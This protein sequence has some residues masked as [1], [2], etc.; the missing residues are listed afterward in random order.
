MSYYDDTLKK[1]DKLIDEEKYEE[2]LDI[3]KEELSLAYV[4]KEFEDKFK[5]LL[6]QISQY[7]NNSSKELSDEEIINYLHSDKE[8]QLIGVSVLASKNLRNYVDEV[9]EYLSGDG[10]INAKVILIDELI[11]QELSET[12]KYINEGVEYEFIP[13]YILSPENSDGYLE[14]CQLLQDEYLK[15]P[16]KYRLAL[17]LLYKEVILMLPLSPEKQEGE[18]LFNRIVDYIN[19]AFN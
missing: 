4:P 11:K 16:S 6:S 8:K 19:K 18:L 13:K 7:T 10:F 3:L 1:I 14:A 9:N 2:A 17:D 5:N 12:F 15:E